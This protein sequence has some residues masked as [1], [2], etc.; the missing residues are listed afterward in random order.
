MKIF[1][2]KEWRERKEVITTTCDENIFKRNWVFVQIRAEDHLHVFG[3]SFYNFQFDLIHLQ[4]PRNLALIFFFFIILTY[5]SFFFQVSLTKC[6]MDDYFSH[7]YQVQDFGLLRY[8]IIQVDTQKLFG[9][10]IRVIAGL[11]KFYNGQIHSA[12][13]LPGKIVSHETFQNI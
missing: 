8:P 4:I 11:R 6:L 13:F 2:R 9:N 12:Y 5:F 10:A 3:L 7:Q 1:L